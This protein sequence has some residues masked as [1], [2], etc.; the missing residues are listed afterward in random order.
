MDRCRVEAAIYVVYFVYEYEYYII[1]VVLMGVR[2]F[3]SV[4]EAFSSLAFRG[5]RRLVRR[6]A[7]QPGF[8]PKVYKGCSVFF[9]ILLCMAGDS[10]RQTG[11]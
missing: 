4:V 9:V 1:R 5:R 11:R 7:R 8:Q 3:D 2:G 10:R 6:N